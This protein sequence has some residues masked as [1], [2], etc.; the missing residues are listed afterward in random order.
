MEYIIVLIGCSLCSLHHQ[1]LALIL[2]HFMNTIR[3]MGHKSGN[4]S[5]IKLLIWA[6]KHLNLYLVHQKYIYFIKV[7]HV[8]LHYI[9]YNS[10]YHYAL[11]MTLYPWYYL[12][13]TFM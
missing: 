6:R 9:I 13:L 10:S 8:F 7:Y 2:M 1:V 12:L 5:M 11:I 3:Y 4:H